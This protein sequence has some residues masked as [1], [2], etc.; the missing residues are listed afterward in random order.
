MSLLTRV[1][2]L[3]GSTVIA[4]VAGA[5]A[6]LVGLDAFVIL[7][8]QLGQVGKGTYS[9]STAFV[10]VAWT[11]PR[12]MVEMFGSAAAIGGVLG[13]G[14]LAPTAELTAMRAGGM[15]KLRIAQGAALGVVA[16]LLVV[17]VV[18]ETLAPLGEARAQALSA[19][20]K[21]RDLVATGRTGL[22]AREGRTVINARGGTVGADGVTL[23]DVR[24]FEFRDDGSLARVSQG[25]RALH[26][27]GHWTLAELSHYALGEQDLVASSAKEERW[28]TAL[29]PRLLSVSI[30]E[31]AYL[32][33]RDLERGIAHLE[34]N[35]VDAT[36][37]RTAFW[38]RVFYPLDVLA[39]AFAS[40]PFAFGALR[41]G[42]LGKRLFLGV[43]LAVGWYFFQRAAV[44]V[45][46]VYG[47]DFRVAHALPIVVLAAI[48][49]S[50]FR[51]T[52]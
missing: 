11:V 48:A 25:K 26:R 5:W 19:G 33:L 41:S 39:L 23:S 45:A 32:S 21:S 31:P 18:S 51:R 28:D 20:A 13:L 14:A 37:Y 24:I 36:P 42:G 15:S 50:Y 30:V 12:R 7:M 6:V 4:S 47:V 27:D 8:G 38:A 40:L 3:V 52:A 46:V 43:V 9:L 16:L 35:G 34:G 17:M 10:Y 49:Y 1:D 22:W 44:N 29:D 2:W